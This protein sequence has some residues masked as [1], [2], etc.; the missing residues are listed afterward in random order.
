MNKNK[1]KTLSLAAAISSAAFSIFCLTYHLDISLIAFPIALIITGA[2]YFTGYYKLFTKNELKYISI[3][4]EVLQYL[5]YVLLIAFVMRRAGNFGTSYAID[6]IAIVFWI[7]VFV[8]SQVI[9]HYF[10][11]KKI[12]A[13]DTEWKKYAENHGLSSYRG[14][15]RVLMEL[16]SWGDALVQA[17]LMVV[18][19]NIFIVQLYVIPSESMVP[20]FLIND[21]VVVFKITS[22]PKFPLSNV[23][24]PDLKKY[25]RGDIVVFRNPNYSDDRQSEVKSFLSQ[26]VT[27]LTLTKVNLNTDENGQVKADPLVKRVCGIPGEQLMMQDGVLYSRT[28]ES[29]EWKAVEMD[30]KY[31]EWNLNQVKPS[32]RK[33]NGIQD[34]P[35]NQK[36]YE[37]MIDFEEQRRNFDVTVFAKEAQN[38]SRQFKLCYERYGNHNDASDLNEYFDSNNRFEFALFMNRYKNAELLLSN[39]DGWKWFNAFMT[40]WSKNGK[41]D[42]E[43]NLY[44]QS[45]YILNLM[46]KQLVGRLIV[47]EA[48]LIVEGR[49]EQSINRDPG[50]AEIMNEAKSLH[51]YI[52]LLDRRNM[53]AF[54]ENDSEGKPQYI[55]E[56]C[57]FMMGDNRFN[58][59]DM[60]HCYNPYIADLTKYDPYSVTYYSNMK[61][62]YVHKNKILGSP[63]YRFWPMERRG[64]P[65]FTGK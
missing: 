40:E 10:N 32:L 49:P 6:F 34:Y 42:F 19:L 45:N 62:R 17:V 30:S 28:K 23:G 5:P 35:L 1:L 20:E 41:P 63:S 51:N 31:A 2:C 27:M 9:V 26:I 22:G 55:P 18:V 47:R 58:S 46:T 61:P 50:I 12:G 37:E 15:K 44:E 21:R 59:Q 14:K 33:N 11:V 29:D 57:F 8:L 64:V 65:G 53:P 52:V 13:I 54:P 7:I 60:R 16:L 24:F 56:N 25:K 4:Q 38:I 3:F 43:G 39:K 36:E 48:Q